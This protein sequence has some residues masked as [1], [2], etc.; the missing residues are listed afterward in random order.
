MKVQSPAACFKKYLFTEER[1]HQEQIQVASLTTSRNRVNPEGVGKGSSVA[2]CPISVLVSSGCQRP[3]RM[4]QKRKGDDNPMSIELRML[5]CKTAATYQYL[6]VRD[7]LLDSMCSQVVFSG[8]LLHDSNL[9]IRLFFTKR[10]SCLCAKILAS[11]PAIR[12]SALCASK[13]NYWFLLLNLTRSVLTG[14]ELRVD[15][16]ARKKDSCPGWFTRR[17]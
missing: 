16:T 12:S 2:E 6:S 1:F 14:R 15:L 5:R 11:P 10:K 4:L 9:L 17:F 8:V 13:L 7:T 3:K